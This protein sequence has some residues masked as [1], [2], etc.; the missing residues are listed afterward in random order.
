[1]SSSE[2]Q[3]IDVDRVSDIQH[4]HAAVT[5]FLESR[6]FDALLLQRPSNFSWFTSGGDCSRAGSCDAAA[7]LFITPDA[8]VVVT[9]NAESAQ[10]FDRELQG[11]G[12]QLKNAPGTNRGAL[13]SRTSSADDRSPATRDSA[14]PMKR[15]RN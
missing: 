7:A 14:A 9:T 15:R 2:F 3:T 12:F 4:K 11:L 10:L 6:R 8:R 13:L 1:M 5:Q